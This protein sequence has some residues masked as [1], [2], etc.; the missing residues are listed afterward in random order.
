MKKL[1][2]L[3]LGCA[4]LFAQYISAQDAPEKPELLVTLR[5]FN[6]NG[7][8]QYLK[9]KTMTKE[10]G[11]LL[12]V[13]SAVLQ[14]YLDETSPGNL[15]SSMKTDE[16]GEGKAVIPPSLKEQ[17][18]LNSSHKFIAVT[19]ATKKFE[20]TTTELEI[21]KAKIVID[22][23]N[24]DNSRKVSVQVLSFD[25]S[26]W[27]PAKEIEIKIGVRR[28]GGDLKIGEEE[29]FTTDSLGQAVGEFKLDSLPAIDAKNNI[30]LVAKTEDNELFGNIAF[31]KTV[32]W[33]QYK[34]AENNFDRR[35]LW[36]TRDKA[37]FWLLFMAFSVIAG[38]WG[39]IIY[40]IFQII[41]IRKLR[42]EKN[43]E[44]MLPELEKVEML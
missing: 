16:N 9:V 23:L 1:L 19:Q 44:E 30:V 12:P 18:S 11:K 15:I 24:E 31:E 26:G 41:K 33:G 29:T 25:S 37:P 7:N 34:T 38:V 8:L 21:A 20:E 14:L 43:A 17:W 42:N 32:P 39:V 27:V 40:L 35:T 6:T 36:G 3:S 4:L 28:L 10:D 22:T 13:Q 5:Y 2:S